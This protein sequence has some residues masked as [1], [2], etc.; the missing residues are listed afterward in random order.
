M[1]RL[2]AMLCQ[3]RVQLDLILSA[4]RGYR[5]FWLQRTPHDLLVHWR[6][7]GTAGIGP[8]V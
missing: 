4:R 2:R 7:L 6:W 3:L 1:S 8:R 5:W